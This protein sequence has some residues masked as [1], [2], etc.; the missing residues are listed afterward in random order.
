MAVISFKCPNCDGELIF[1]P[2]TQKYKCEYCVSTFTQE[3]LDNMERET[4]VMAFRKRLEDR[5]GKIPKEANELIRI[6]SLRRL[7]RTLGIEK[8]ALKQKN[9]YIYFVGE[10]NRAYY[11]SPAFGKILH[12]LQN[13]PQRCRLRE[14]NGKRS[15]LISGV[16]TVQEAVG[17][18]ASMSSLSSI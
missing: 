8:V 18:L 1:D 3:E 6:V 4:D 15:I 7:A 13:D 14:V 11:E 9:M 17:I 2:A 5:F 10:E 16:R 12:Y